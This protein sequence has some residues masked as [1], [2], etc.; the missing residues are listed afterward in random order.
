MSGV[1]RM[2]AVARPEL[3]PVPLMSSALRSVQASAPLQSERPM[4]PTKHSVWPARIEAGWLPPKRSGRPRGM[5]QSDWFWMTPKRERGMT[6]GANGFPVNG[7]RGGR[8]RCKPRKTRYS[9]WADDRRVGRVDQYS[10]DAT[11][12][13]AWIEDGNWCAIDERVF[14]HRRDA[15]RWVEAHPR[16]VRG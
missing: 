3:H 5:A 10:V 7:W 8:D 9:L 11:S 4:R 13:I 12:W 15:K 16:R 6:R 14:G 1:R 2:L